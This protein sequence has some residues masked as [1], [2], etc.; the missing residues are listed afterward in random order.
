LCFGALILCLGKPLIRKR[1]RV[2][3]FSYWL[4][5]QFPRI[6]RA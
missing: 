2:C 6:A 5:I 4:K 3:G 1:V